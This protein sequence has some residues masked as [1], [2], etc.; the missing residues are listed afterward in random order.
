MTQYDYKYPI[1]AEALLCCH[2]GPPGCFCDFQPFPDS[3]GLCL[4]ANI[5]AFPNVT[6]DPRVTMQPCENVSNVWSGFHNGIW[7]TVYYRPDWVQLEVDG[8]SH[9]S[10]FQCLAPERCQ[11]GSEL[12]T[13]DCRG[14]GLTRMHPDEDTSIIRVDDCP[15]FCIAPAFAGAKLTTCNH[16]ETSRLVV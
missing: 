12:H 10:T 4:T 2:D 8:L 5:K 9:Y 7:K 16:V 15:G 11:D 1:T 3:H 13:V 6:D 14:P